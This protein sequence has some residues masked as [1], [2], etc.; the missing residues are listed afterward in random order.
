[1]FREEEGGWQGYWF[2]VGVSQEDREEKNARFS[3]FEE[4]A[5]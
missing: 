5:E 3:E 4:M 2:N 1:M